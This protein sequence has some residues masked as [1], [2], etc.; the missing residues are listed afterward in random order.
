MQLITKKGWFSFL[1]TSQTGTR[2]SSWAPPCTR[3]Y[4]LQLS[5]SLAQ[6]TVY[7]SVS[8]GPDRVGTRRRYLF[9][10]PI[11]IESERIGEEDEL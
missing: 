10:S 8:L 11:R 5:G 9:S 1:G 6:E 3:R 2:S 7:G 4:A